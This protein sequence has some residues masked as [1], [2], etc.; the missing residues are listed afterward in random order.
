MDRCSYKKLRHY[1]KY[2]YKIGDRLIAKIFI[3]FLIEHGALTPFNG[4]LTYGKGFDVYRRSY[5]NLI[6]DAFTWIQ[7]RE[8]HDY[9]SRLNNLWKEKYFNLKRSIGI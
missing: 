2:V 5:G 7:T 3:S 8:G 6:C 4:R 9:W 1:L